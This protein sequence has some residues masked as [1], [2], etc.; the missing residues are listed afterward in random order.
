MRT[1]TAGGL[2][3]VLLAVLGARAVAQEWPSGRMRPPSADF[4]APSWFSR[5]FGGGP[6]PAEKPAPKPEKKKNAAKKD[7]PPAEPAPQGES[8]GLVRAREEAALLRRMDVCDRLRAVALL[9]KD[10]DL[11]RKAD[12]LEERAQAAYHER[13]AH[14]PAG[15]TGLESDLNTVA[16]PRGTGERPPA[17]GRAIQGQAGARRP[18]DTGEER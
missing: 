16:R 13:T 8:P 2:G 3:V 10:D 7:T 12:Q 5:M 15:H 11:L 6:K 17:P 18:A 4:A 9:T 14:L 1:K